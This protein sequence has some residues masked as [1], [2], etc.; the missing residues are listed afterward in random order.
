MRTVAYWRE[1]PDVVPRP[2]TQ[3]ILDVALV[4]AADSARVQFGLLVAERQHGHALH[5]P[6]TITSADDDV[7]SLT[8]WI[9]GSNTSDDAVEQLD[10]AANALAELHTQMPARQLLSDVR[11]LQG[12]AQLLLRSGRQRLR[13]TRDLIRIDGSI[14]AHAGRGPTVVVSLRRVLPR[15]P[16]QRDRAYSQPPK[17]SEQGVLGL[18][19]MFDVRTCRVSKGGV[20]QV[21]D[22]ITET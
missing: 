5:Q 13:Q 3:E 2:V 11:Q 12:Q 20:R 1:R 18:E 6:I 17:L 15:T 19:I 7:A 4:R 22:R 10:R 8:A 21:G 9:T 14:L 16:S